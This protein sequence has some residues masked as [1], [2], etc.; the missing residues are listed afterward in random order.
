MNENYFCDGFCLG[1][2][3]EGEATKICNTSKTMKDTG[4]V[5]CIMYDEKSNSNPN[6]TKLVVNQLWVL[7]SM[8]ELI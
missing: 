8:L 6:K 1:H 2:V 3:D 4:K 7:I 5:L